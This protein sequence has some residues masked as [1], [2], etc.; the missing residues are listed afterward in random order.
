MSPMQIQLL[1]AAWDRM[2]RGGYSAQPVD[3][4]YIVRGHI[5][6]PYLLGLDHSIVDLSLWERLLT[7]LGLWDAWD[8][9]ARRFPLPASGD[10]GPQG[11]DP[12][13][14]SSSGSAVPS[15]ETADA[16]P[17]APSKGLTP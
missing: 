15:E 17:L 12:K 8:I 6:G 11:E 5:D 2:R 16:H 1:I 4:P 9:E 14:L 10:A 7:K 13:G 3:E